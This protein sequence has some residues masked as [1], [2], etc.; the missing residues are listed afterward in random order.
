[1]N[2][3]LCVLVDECPFITIVLFCLIQVQLEQIIFTLLFPF[4]LV[5]S[6]VFVQ[7]Q[8]EHTLSVVKLSEIRVYIGLRIISAHFP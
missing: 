1:M 8:A 6:F 5:C 3:E 2:V 7:S 4:G